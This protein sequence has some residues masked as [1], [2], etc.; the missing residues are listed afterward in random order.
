ML[1]TLIIPI[2]NS[3]LVRKM[4]K[5]LPST[6]D[7]SDKNIYLIHVSDP[8][9]VTIYSEGALSEYYISE[10]SH[11]QACNEIAEIIFANYKKMLQ[12]CAQ[13]KFI[14]EFNS[15][16]P[17]AIVKASKKYK[18]DAIVMTSHRYTGMNNVF[19]GDKAHKVIVNTKI[20]VLVL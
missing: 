10:K 5:K 17:S 14:H 9:P 11:R 2:D 12:P 15:D 4:I 3:P 19:L 13:L 8:Y 1:T 16:I 20:P 6:L 7:L 18:A